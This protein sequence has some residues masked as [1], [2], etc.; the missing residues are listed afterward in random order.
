MSP[1]RRPHQMQDAE[2]MALPLYQGREDEK[3]RQWYYMD[4]QVQCYFWD[5][6]TKLSRGLRQRRLVLLISRN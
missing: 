1:Y 2:G 6:V 3:R 5:F 4:P